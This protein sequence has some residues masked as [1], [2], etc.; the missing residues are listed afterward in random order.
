MTGR[1]RS[2]PSAPAACPGSAGGAGTSSLRLPVVTIARRAEPGVARGI[3]GRLREAEIEAA[4]QRPDRARR[5]PPAPERALRHPAVDQDQRNVARRRR[6]DQVRPQIGFHEQREIGPPVIEKARDEPRQVDRHELMDHARRQPFF[7]EP[8]RGH[9][10]DVTST[11]S[12]ARGCARSAAGWTGV[13]RR[14]RHASRPA[15]RPGARS[16]LSPRRSGNAL[17]MLL[18]ALEPIPETRDL[19]AA[20]PRRQRPIGMQ[21]QR[22]AAQPRARPP[23]DPSAIS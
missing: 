17:G 13:R 16:P 22:A 2:R 7:G 11:V 6:H 12:R 8:G 5:E 4:K 23:P 10:P 20:R 1:V 14:S 19:P 21:R 18:A 3:V 9:G 15:A